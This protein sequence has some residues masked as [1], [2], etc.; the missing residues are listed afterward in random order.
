M[1]SG[2]LRAGS[3]SRGS[4][5]GWPVGREGSDPLQQPQGGLKEPARPA[6]EPPH[7]QHRSQPDQQMSRRGGRGGPW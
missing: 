2:G 3:T 1:R 6:K 4:G 5:Q 7:P